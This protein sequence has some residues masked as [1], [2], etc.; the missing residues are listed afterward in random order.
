MWHSALTCSLDL[1]STVQP[2][3]NSHPWDSKKVAVVGRWPLWRGQIYSKT[4]LW[5]YWKLAVI[6]RWLLLRGDRSWR[7]HCTIIIQRLR[8]YAPQTKLKDK[9]G[10]RD[11]NRKWMQVE[12]SFLWLTLRT[13]LFYNLTMYHSNISNGSRLMLQKPIV[14]AHPTAGLPADVQ[15]FH[16][17]SF[18]LENQVKN[19]RSNHDLVMIFS[20]LGPVVQSI[21]SLTSSLRGQLVRCLM[22]L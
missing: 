7:F 5:G 17:Q 4:A 6:G 18:L 10:S 3:Y 12:L 9:Y 11:I 20:K 2:P 19:C 13:D 14:D 22:T 15:H 8:S 1:T 16:N 21:V